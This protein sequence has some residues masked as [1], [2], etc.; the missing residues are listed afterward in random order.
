MMMMT[1]LAFF[2]SAASFP[3]EA[4][5]NPAP[6][7]SLALGYKV[8]NRQL[9]TEDQDRDYIP[10]ESVIAWTKISGIPTGFVEHVWYRGGKEVARHYLPVSNGR[11]WRTWSR[12]TV[13]EG[14]YSVV[15]LGPDGTELAKKEFQVQ[16][17]D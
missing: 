11:N 16:V 7:V 4:T 12:H 10:G 9:V 15:V 5:S 14:A 2:L 1:G 13:Q 8:V 3:G 17:G 6:E